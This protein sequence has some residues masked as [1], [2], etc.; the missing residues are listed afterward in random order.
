M[1]GLTSCDDARLEPKVC[2]AGIP[3]TAIWAGGADGGAYMRCSIDI[4]KNVNRCSVWND[5]T[6]SLVESGEY[7]LIRENRA[8]TESELEFSGAD[9]NGLIFLEHDQILKHR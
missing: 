7:R 3:N 6:G 8:A 5:F 2:P 9:F 4:E 1:I